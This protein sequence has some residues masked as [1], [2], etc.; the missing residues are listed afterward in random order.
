MK[1]RG[2]FW[3]LRKRI[4]WRPWQYIS[5]VFLHNLQFGVVEAVRGRGLRCPT[6]SVRTRVRE[7][8]RVLACV[9]T[10][11]RAIFET[12]SGVIV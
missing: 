8:G 11:V 7:E 2:G 6:V 4:P 12:A 5:S 9:P 1:E 10:V 3:S